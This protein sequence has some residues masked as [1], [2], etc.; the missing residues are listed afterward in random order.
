MTAVTSTSKKS[1]FGVR[2]RSK[3]AENKK[4]FIVNIIL[5]LIG[6]PLIAAMIIYI[7]HLTETEQN[8]FLYEFGAESII[9]VSGIAIFLSILSG[10]VIALFSYRYLYTKSLV[11]MNY[12]LPLTSKQRFFA[13]YLAGLTM[14]IA[15]AFAAAAISLIILGIGSSFV[16]MSEFWN[17]FS[18]ILSIGFIV[19]VGMLMLYTLTVFTTSICGATFEAVFAVIATN[20]II[21]ATVAVAF[22]TVANSAA[23]YGFTEASLYY[24]KALTTTSPVGNLVFM[25]TYMDKYYIDTEAC[26]SMYIRWLIPVLLIIAVY[27][28]GAMLLYNRRKA[29]SV[30]KPYVYKGY[31]YTLVTLSVF[32]IL[33]EFIVNETNIAAGLIICGIIYFLLEVITKRGFRKFWVSVLRYAATVAAV[34]VFCRISDLT[35]G[36]GICN[37]VPKANSVSSVELYLYGQTYGFDRMIS[38]KDSDVINETVEFHEDLI[39]IYKNSEEYIDN[40]KKISWKE[41]GEYSDKTYADNDDVYIDV[42]YNMKNGST[43]IREY[44]I[45]SD[46]I[47]ELCTAIM[48]SD[49]FAAY[50]STQLAIDCFNLYNEYYFDNFNEILKSTKGSIKLSD[51]ISDEVITKRRMDYNDIN[52]LRKAYKQDLLDMTEEDLKNAPIYGYLNDFYW[53]KDTFTN[54]IEYLEQKGFKSTEITPEKLLEKQHDNLRIGIFPEIKIY[55]TLNSV[56]ESEEDYFY[57]QEFELNEYIIQDKFT[58]SYANYVAEQPT[59]PVTYFGDCEELAELLKKATS[60]IIDDMPA[61]VVCIDTEYGGSY[62]FYIPDTE[63][64]RELLEKLYEEYVEG[65]AVLRSEISSSYYY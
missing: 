40:A 5:Q 16:D 42:T 54:T 41:L 49:E 34:F 28:F 61:G 8:E 47:G 22:F 32:C 43:V 23:Y 15:P 55:N 33:S 45:S 36:F 35:Y 37:Y 13:D 52:E 12:S 51:C 56:L 60:T 39:D 10:I 27:L 21:P 18:F 17:N 38:F 63:E 58:R 48:L 24:G 1:F 25:Y 19:I 46:Y 44:C 53:I 20:I 6:L 11:D 64:N 7:K 30:S 3:I 9:A 65:K 50:Q 29:E 14:Y 57:A 4:L 59:V 62:V 26:A 2:Y 31:Y